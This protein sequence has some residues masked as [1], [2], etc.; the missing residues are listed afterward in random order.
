MHHNTI[1]FSEQERSI[2]SKIRMLPPDKIAEV[3]DFVD[4]ISQKN[5]EQQLRK[6]A[7]KIAEDAFKKVW[8]NAEDDV[9]DRL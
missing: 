1:S 2:L 9:Y 7:G 4:F 5:Q 3:S 8:D 6:A